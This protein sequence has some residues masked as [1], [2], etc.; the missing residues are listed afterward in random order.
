MGYVWMLIPVLPI[1]V[2][3]A[4]ISSFVGVIFSTISRGGLQ[5][6]ET[7]VPALAQILALYALAIFSIYL[8]LLV[9]AFAMYYLI[10]RRNNHFRR[11]QLLFSA[12]NS[13]LGQ[14]TRGAFN[15]AVFRLEESSQD[16]TFEERDRPAGLWSVLYLFVT[17][18]VGLIVGYALTQDLRRHEE[19][20]S[21]YQANLVSAL[22]ENGFE[23]PAATPSRAHRRDA[24]LFVI[25][26]AITGGLF[27]IYWFYTLLKD[28]N[29]HFQDQTQFEDAIFTQLRPK[30]A[31]KNCVNC[32]A[33]IAETSKF[34]P[35]CGKQQS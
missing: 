35:L 16:S 11:Q 19:L 17:P 21:S 4:L 15:S 20:Q 12:L 29:D 27:W 24:I 10:E 22:K 30:P 13:F 28:Y 23:P 3:V 14:K 9:G 31:T 5:Q 32:G 7:A 34:C 8:I 25:L 33:Q 26:T 1:I 18:I 2:G 6:P